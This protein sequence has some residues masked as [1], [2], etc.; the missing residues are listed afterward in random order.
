VAGV[1]SYDKVLRRAN[2]LYEQAKGYK[3][4][5]YKAPEQRPQIPSDQVKSVLRALIE[6]LND[7]SAAAV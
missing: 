4:D 6:A 2:E 7:Q 3:W 1:I 5:G